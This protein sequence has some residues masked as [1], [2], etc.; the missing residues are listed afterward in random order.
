MIWNL[1]MNARLFWKQSTKKFGHHQMHQYQSFSRIPSNFLG[2]MTAIIDA[3]GKKLMHSFNKWNVKNC[4][5]FNLIEGASSLDLILSA[6]D[7]SAQTFHYGE[8]SPHVPICP[9]DVLGHKYISSQW[10]F[11]HWYFSAQELI[12]IIF[13]TDAFARRECSLLLPPVKEG[14]GIIQLRYA[15]RS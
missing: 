8:I 14:R 9:V 1:I 15:P 6:P 10:T 5:C 7:I 3:S 12:L 13:S 11:Q 2:K 4:R